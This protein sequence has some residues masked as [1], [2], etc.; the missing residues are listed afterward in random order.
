LKEGGHQNKIIKYYLNILKGIQK[1]Y[2][3]EKNVE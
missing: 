3:E 2:M 1:N